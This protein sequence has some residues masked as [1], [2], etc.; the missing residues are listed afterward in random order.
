MK[1]SMRCRIAAL[2]VTAAACVGTLFTPVGAHAQEGDYQIFPTPQ[3]VAYQEGSVEFADNVTTVVEDGIDGDT[4]ARLDEAVKLKAK[5]VKSADAVPTSGTAVLVGV[6]GSGKQVDSYVKQL[7]DAKKLAYDAKLFE[8]TDANLVALLPAEDGAANRIIVLG[9]D[10][11]SAFYGLS[12]VFQILQQDADSSLRALVASDH[13]DVIT[14]GFI[15]GYYGNPWSTRDRVAL[16]EWGGY[17]KLNAYF[18]AP[19]DDPKHNAQWREKYTQAE[20]DEKIKPLAEA[21]NKSKV[22]FVYALHPF[23]HNPITKDN[24]DE[25]FEIMKA[26]FLQ[27]IDAGTR[28]ISILADDAGYQL[29]P[30]ES[31]AK[32]TGEL[33]K[34][35]L[36]DTT[37]WLHELQ[38]QKNS[39]GS[40]KYPG[41]KDT[42]IFCPV[43]YM[44]HG[45]GWYDT[46]P[47]NVQVINTGGEVWGRLTRDFAT[48]F[49]SNSGVAPF[50][51]INWPCSDNDKNVLHMGGHNVF[52]GSGLEPGMVEGIV[53]NPMQQSEPSKQGIFMT[54]DYTWNLWESPEHGDDVWSK[55]F[56]YIDHNSGKETEASN[57][58]R[59]LSEHMK[60]MYGHNVLRVD[61]ESAAIAEPLTDFRAKLTSD[62]VTEA[63]LDA[64]AKIYTDLQAAAKAYR[65]GAGTEAMAEQ[66]KPWID[67]W[68]DLTASALT[69]IEAVRAHLAGNDS[70]LIEKYAEATSQLEAANGHALWYVDHYEYA[71]VGRAQ[72]TPTVS[73]LD[74]YAAEK[75]TLAAD[76]DAVVTK[77]VTN[78]TDTPVGSVANVF[79]GD[80]KTGAIYQTP[81][82]LAKGDFFG[83]VTNKPFDLTSV[84]FVQ[85]GGKDFMDA[86]K[87]QYLKDGQWADVEGSQEFNTSK[88]ILTG[89]DIK[90]VE[91]VRIIA[92]RDNR[93]D[94]WPTINEIMVN[95]QFEENAVFTGTVTVANQESADDSKPIQNAS[96]GR[97][98]EAWFTHKKAE[99]NKHDATIKDAAVQVTFDVPKTITSITFKQG[100]GNSTD[101]IESGK[102]YYQGAD[103][104][105]HE[106]G[107]ITSAKSQTVQLAGPVA[108][109]AIKVV[110]GANT[111]KWWRVV[112]LHAGFGKIEAI[113]TATT[114]MPQYENNPIANA[115]D[116]NAESTFFSNRNTQANDYVM[117]SFSAPKLIDTV[118][119]K[120]GDA[121]K[122]NSSKLYYTT[123]AAPSANGNWTE[124]ATPTS[125][126]EQTISFDRVEATGVKLVATAATSNRFQLFEF[127]AF[128]KFSYTKDN[129]YASFDLAN[130]GLAARVGDG[131]FK[132][133]DG[134]V[135]LPKKGD[136]IA[137]DLGSVRRD[138][139]LANADAQRATQAD[140]V[141]S[142]NGIEWMSLEGT[143]PVRARYVGYRAA[144]DGAAVDF[145]ALAGT[146][147]HTLAPSIV[148]SELPGAQTLDVAKVFDGNV[149]TA[150]KSSGGPSKGAKVV[151][152]LGQERSIKSVEYFVPENSLDFIRFGVV[153]VADRAD[154]PD[155]EWKT[156]LD[157]NGDGKVDDPGRDATAKQAPWMTHSKDFPGNMF[158]KSG[159]GLDETARYMRIRFTNA[160]TN[161]WFEIGELRING[162]EYVPVYAGGDFETTAVEQQG[163]TPDNLLDKSVLTA[164]QPATDA[165]GTLTYHVSAPI[166]ADGEPFDGVRV[167]SK[168][169]QPAVKVKAVVY[170]GDLR[171][172]EPATKTVELG[173]L[174]SV[175]KDLSFGKGVSAVKDI[176][177]EWPKGTVPQIS[178]IFLTRGIE[179][180]LDGEIEA[181]CGL[182]AEAKAA[183]TT[184]WTTDSVT[185][186]NGAVAAAEE[187]LK[188]PEN[189]TYQQIVDLK[190]GIEGALSSPVLKYVGTELQQLIDS[191]VV[192]GSKFTP[193]SWKAY[194]DA[195]DA[196]KAGLE[197]VDNLSQAEGDRLARELKDAL[198]ALVENADQGGSGSGNGG[199]DSGNT[200]NGGQGGN[201]VGNGASGSAGKPGSSS[202]KLVQ[203]GDD[204]LMLIG[205]TA[206]AAV[207][208]AGAGIAL[209]RRRSNA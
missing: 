84:T 206:F 40:L 111:E 159:E 132:T 80:P 190:A 51:W 157:I 95:K 135:A 116:G 121:D 82:K 131:S 7:V 177:F 140:L 108:A 207:A 96:D 1:Q 179:A 124:L 173:V 138:V 167:I 88:V 12:T 79:D 18:Y 200:G 44:G 174:D 26:K 149:A 33:Y 133:T 77:L 43:A 107:A 53:I 3:K 147:L 89:L 109:K 28:Q 156:V 74:A 5:S 115:V 137:V 71:R 148:K 126:S 83:M 76:P 118:Y 2:A 180:S 59:E 36:E 184:A 188:A 185:A 170:S 192:D 203:T 163:K 38:G 113:A 105:W 130:V 47:K 125:A 20:I 134:S 75:A 104:V 66:M 64:V 39:D 103:D 16:M 172:G 37:K 98:T 46:L 24:Y 158:V 154:A 186:L 117:L 31:N 208:L 176:V 162:G 195:L 70:A 191:A 27:V 178:E 136:V 49:K 145:K 9:K 187:A 72:I 69:Y 23:M 128:E 25:T 41:L 161:R 8:Q 87:V 99:P 81:N 102:A 93:Q 120:Q 63:D 123:D 61:G 65:A 143:D 73:A 101:V 68:D 169:A 196:A 155:A 30:N 153:E 151:F 112:D 86:S 57:A 110:N 114:N 21:G 22:R 201:S 13:A 160:Y 17:Y 209:K 91:G 15:E 141:Y 55:S 164:W 183:D 90:G 35:L 100:G 182:V 129:L 146:Y 78:R 197:N 6:H 119:L 11:D 52:L 4:K 205:G 202:D 152:D 50:M 94:A 165:A 85:G 193:E 45:E 181:L 171:A 92:V 204:S 168:L 127:N 97:D 54:A 144:A 67:T 106:A 34:K 32:H 14:R 139:V 150:T 62:T 199:S 56:S 198:D 19:K 189:L 60:R 142:Q 175:L 29:G 166:S 58:L 194:Q 122:F 42:L 48:T 10:T